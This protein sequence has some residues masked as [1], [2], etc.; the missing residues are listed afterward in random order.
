MITNFN[1]KLLIY[2]NYMHVKIHNILR[3]GLLQLDPINLKSQ[4]ERK[5]VRINW[6]FKLTR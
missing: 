5:M 6:G 4:G 1:N 2:N 3:I